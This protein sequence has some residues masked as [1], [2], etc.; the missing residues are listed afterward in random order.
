VAALAERLAERVAADPDSPLRASLDL[1]L[2]RLPADVRRLAPRL[3]VLQGGGME[4][5][6]REVTRLE[7]SREDDATEQARELLALLDGDTS[8]E[9]LV[10]GLA[11]LAGLDLPETIPEALAA[12]LARQLREGLA[13]Q[14]EMLH[15]QVAAHPPPT[16]TD[17][18]TWPRLR[19][20]LTAAAQLHPEAVPGGTFVRLHP[21]LAP[22]LWAE[23][24]E[25][26]RADLAA[27]H[28]RAYAALARELYFLDDKDPDRARAVVRRELPNLMHAVRAALVAGEEG[29]VGFADNVGLFLKHFGLNRDRDRLTELAGKAKGEVGSDDWFIARSNQGEGLLD[30][31]R[32]D[33]ALEVFQEILEG[34]S[35]APS[36]QR[37][38]TLNRLGLCHKAM[39][40]TDEAVQR[41]REA[42][43]VAQGLEQSGQVRRQQGALQKDL[44]DALRGLGEYEQ[45]RQAYMASLAIKK[46]IGDPRGEGVV[47]GQLGALAL[48]EGKLNEAV[49]RYQQ[50]LET[51]QRLGEPASE[52]IVWHQLGMAYQKAGEWEAAERAYRESARLEEQLGNIAGAASTWGQL[53]ILA[54]FTHRPA[55]AEAWYRKA[56]TADEE[57]RNSAAQSVTLSNL[58]NLLRTLPGRLDEACDLAE[59]ALT[60]KETL[61]P[62][63]AE[64]WKTHGL[65]AEIAAAQGRQDQARAA[66]AAF[67]GARHHLAPIRDLLAAA[68][69]AA[70]GERDPALADDLG[71][72]AGT[73][74]D[75]TLQAIDDPA[76]LDRFFGCRRAGR[77]ELTAV[78]W[79]PRSPP[80]RFFNTAGPVDPQRHYCIP[81]L[82]R[83][84]LDEVLMLIDQHQYFVLHAPRQTGKTTSLLALRDHLNAAGDYRCV[85]VNV[86]VGQSAREDVTAA[87]RAIIGEIGLRAELDL[88]DRFVT[89][90]L[91]E[92]IARRGGHGA[93]GEVLTR[94]AAASPKPLVL[95]IDEIDALVGDTLVSTL[96]QLRAGYAGR[97]RQFPQ[98]VVLCG[99]R[100]V[101]DYRIHSATD[102]AVITGGSAFNIK[103]ESLRIGD[104]VQSEIEALNAE[105]TGQAFV[106]AALARIWDLTRGQPWLVNAL[107]YEVCFRSKEARDRGLP[108]TLAMVEQAKEALILR[109]D[110]HLDQL[111]DK[112]QEERVRRVMAPLLASAA[113]S[114]R[115]HPD[116]VQYL[117]DL[118]LI[119]R[120]RAGGIALANPIYQE[121]VPRELAWTLQ[122]GIPQET[123]WY[124]RSDGPLDL[125]RLLA[126]FQQ[127]FREH[128]EHWVERFQY[129]EAGPQ[130]LMQAFLQRIVNGGGR[131]EREYGLG[132]LRT[133]LLVIWPHDA[134]EQR[135]VIELKVLHKGLAATLAQGLEQTWAYLDRCA[136]EEGHLV[137]FDRTPDKAWEEKLFQR[138]EPFQGHTFTVWG[139]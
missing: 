69:A 16:A 48:K 3:G 103:A 59:Q 19:Q 40:H 116:D 77:A 133:D 136:A 80:M 28:R 111:I 115:F 87:M 57:S 50:A 131:I 112:L 15:Q 107:G 97:P 104:F 36:Y 5:V 121:V 26:D 125:S 105:E 82:T 119:R 106:P 12:E 35:E 93:L 81:P 33:R 135:A 117:V 101:L 99:V 7:P 110:T 54:R 8:N 10:R 122:S 70:G 11:R 13:E 42:L 89:D 79:P 123:A 4:D 53:A 29:A 58:A 102:K 137:I 72:V 22:V 47:L 91:S 1:S 18:D 139:M 2:E 62:A 51:F 24:G 63:A 86:E 20:A 17:P 45:A 46:E 41:Y 68:A 94:W 14:I 25:D 9:A 108:I 56:L 118:G 130:L 84:D 134:G 83:F 67:P 30:A 90:T 109:R 23:L 73:L 55:D 126:A 32:P 78:P 6:I 120:D 88:N 124:L 132:R 34:L 127:F 75:L 52:A 113:S 92:A 49:S 31:G 76:A 100:D 60:L 44:G 74:L 27:R 61:D 128:A 85:Y 39:G 65:L 95:L 43:A 64:V 38:L 37:C 71:Y 21:T 66:Y 98:S 138:E 129:K 114:D 96:R